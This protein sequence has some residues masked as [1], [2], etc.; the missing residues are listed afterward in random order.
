MSPSRAADIRAE[1]AVDVVEM[2]YR[3]DGTEAEWLADVLQRTR[4]DIDNGCGVYA[5]TGYDAVPNLPASP[6]F[7]Q[8]DLDPQYAA[9]LMEANRDAPSAIYDLL[10]KRLVTCGGLAQEL[11]PDSPVVKHFRSLMEPIGVSDG[12]SMFAKDAEGGSVSISAPARKT[13][14]P[15]PRVRGIW[16]RVGLH[17]ASAL[18]LRRKLVAQSAVRDAL[19]DPSGRVHDAGLSVKDDN[20][21]RGALIASVRDMERARSKELRK[22]SGEALELWRGLVAGQWSLVEHWESGDRRYLAAYRNSPEARD[23]RALTPT[24]RSIL[25]YLTHGATNKDIVYALGLPEGTVSTSVTRILKKLRLKRRVDVALLGDPSRMERL[26]I[27]VDNEE[28]GVLAVDARPRGEAAALLS[29]AELEVA[30]YVVRGLSN[31]QIASARQVAVRTVANQVR[32][33]FEKL[34]IENRSQLAQALTRR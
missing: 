17:V 27:A 1:S 20:T 4:S 5:F 21:A 30:T 34:G 19:I 22:S 15:A 28:I 18:R 23:P 12:F 11:G 26:D 8:H 10:R 33:I 6:V 7:V 2:A 32:S 29:D 16:R 31:E 24:E 3:L 9:R 14:H 13:L 25:K